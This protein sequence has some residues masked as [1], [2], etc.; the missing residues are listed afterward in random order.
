MGFLGGTGRGKAQTCSSRGKDAGRYGNATP[1]KPDAVH[2][3]WSS[4]V[5][6]K[7]PQA[8]AF[9]HPMQGGRSPVK[10]RSWNSC[11]GN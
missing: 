2:Q 10:C 9:P 3:S 11:D 5:G 7:Q 4:Q 6:A 8:P 1:Q